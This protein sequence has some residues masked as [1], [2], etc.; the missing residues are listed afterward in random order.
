MEFRLLEYLMRNSGQVLT[1]SMIFE[2]VWNYRFDPYTNL[3]EVHIA[4]LRQKIDM[5]GRPPLIHTVRGS[6]Y[7][8]GTH[9]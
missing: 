5:P 7:Q 3:I 6:G 2:A 8:F 9:P 1:R 4:R